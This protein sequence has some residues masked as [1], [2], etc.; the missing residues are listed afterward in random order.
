MEATDLPHSKQK[1]L[2]NIPFVH[3][4]PLELGFELLDLHFLEGCF[5]ELF[6]RFEPICGTTVK[7]ILGQVGRDLTDRI[8][9]WTL[10][11]I[12]YLVVNPNYEMNRQ[13]WWLTELLNEFL[14]GDLN[15]S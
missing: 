8:L 6:L 3:A 10:D 15:L 9:G 12:I 2:R 7:T 14:S 4:V 11:R 13:T 5:R 1:Q